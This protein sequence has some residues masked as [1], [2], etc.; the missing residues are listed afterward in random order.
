MI[1]PI[2]FAETIVRARKLLG[3]NL[4]VKDSA[5]LI[6]KAALRL[7][8]FIV[9]HHFLEAMAAGRSE[10]SMMHVEGIELS[11]RKSFFS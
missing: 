8:R 10:N 4:G 11:T 6:S 2:G 5:S 1:S 9:P 3:Q 7:E